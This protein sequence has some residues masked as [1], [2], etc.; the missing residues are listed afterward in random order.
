MSGKSI[1]ICHLRIPKVHFRSQTF[2]RFN[3]IIEMT[4]HIRLPRSWL[5]WRGIW[6]SFY[7]CKQTWDRSNISRTH[8][9]IYL[10][11]RAAYLYFNA[12]VGK[13]FEHFAAAQIS[14]QVL[15]CSRKM[16]NNWNCKHSNR[17]QSLCLPT[18]PLLTASGTFAFSSHKTHFLFP[19]CTR[20]FHAIPIFGV[21]LPRAL[22]SE[23]FD[24]LCAFFWH[25][26]ATEIDEIEWPFRMMREN[27]N[28]LSYLGNPLRLLS[29]R[30]EKKKG[31]FFSFR[32]RILC[33]HGLVYGGLTSESMLSEFMLV[34]TV[35]RSLQLD[36]IDFIYALLIRNLLM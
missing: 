16:P 9:W 5:A 25:S 17:M 26:I 34:N 19:T 8:L 13:Y 27:E 1:A 2:R 35:R 12:D 20:Q 24:L 4:S 29:R 6:R 10:Y 32:G 11:L 28:Q 3:W 21:F 36:K 15:S 33:M 23:C 7:R 22:S 31:I 30:W 18:T 14:I